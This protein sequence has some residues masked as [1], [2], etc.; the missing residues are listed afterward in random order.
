MSWKAQARRLV[1]R[2]LEPAGFTLRRFQ[3]ELRVRAMQ[4]PQVRAR[5]ITTFRAALGHSLVAFPEIAGNL[6]DEAAIAAFMDAL[7]QCPVGQDGRGRF[8]RRNAAVDDCARLAPRAG[9]GKRR[10]S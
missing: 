9:G 1:N 4:S 7:P 2:T 3:P 8:F 10:V 5:Q 6:P